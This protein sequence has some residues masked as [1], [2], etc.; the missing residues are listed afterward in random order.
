MNQLPSLKMRNLTIPVPVIQGG[1]GIGLSSYT[2]AGAVAREGGLGVLS[3]AALDRIVSLR[4]GKKLNARD[5]AAQD[6]R[7]AKILADRPNL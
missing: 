4:H 7:D 2:L 6:V 5:A 3:S 1:M